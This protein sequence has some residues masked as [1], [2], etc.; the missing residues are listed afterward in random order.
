MEWLL[1]IKSALSWVNAIQ[2][3]AENARGAPPTAEQI[4]QIKA[5]RQQAESEWASLAPGE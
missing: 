4:E 1:L 2:Q 3:M 5:L